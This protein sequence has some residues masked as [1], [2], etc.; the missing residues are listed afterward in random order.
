[1]AFISEEKSLVAA[2]KGRPFVLIGVNGDEPNNRA[3]VRDAVKKEG[4]TWRSFWAGGPDGAI[5][6]KW[7][8]QGWPTVYTIDAKGIIRDDLF[9]G[10]LSPAAFE[11]LVQEA[12]KASR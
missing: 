10:K 6:R 5:P 12:E 11:S 9:T 3:R 1:M 8:V 7:G 2:M 4:I